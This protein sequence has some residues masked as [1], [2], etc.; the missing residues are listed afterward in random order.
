MLPAEQRPAAISS[1][2]AAR[3]GQ[4]VTLRLATT[5]DAQFILSLRLDPTRSAHISQ[6]SESLIE[7]KRWMEAYAVRFALGEEAYFIIQHGGVDVG[8]VRLYG[9]RPD[10]A[11]FTW[12]SWIIK[13][14]TNPAAGVLTQVLVYDLAFSCLGFTSAY[15]NVRKNN[16]TVWKFHELLGAKLVAENESD[17]SYTFSSEMYPPARA[18]LIKLTGMPL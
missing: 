3:I 5:N 16:I 7:Q 11:A 10:R 4:P 18:K 12:G 15:F 2:L 9:Y 8:T 14:G 13:T 17:K 6:T 1:W